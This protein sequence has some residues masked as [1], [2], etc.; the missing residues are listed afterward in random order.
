MVTG[1]GRKQGPTDAQNAWVEKLGALGGTKVEPAKFAGAADETR[2]SL[3]GI[4]PEDIPFTVSCDCTITNDT[5]EILRLDVA[6]IKT[7]SGRLSPA[8]P[9]EIDKR[10]RDVPFRASNNPPFLRGAVG[11]LEYVIDAQGTRWKIGWDNPRFN[12][13]GN[14][15]APTSVEGP[16]K[17]NFIARSVAGP[18]DKAKFS[19]TLKAKGGGGPV[20]PVPPGPTPAEVKSSC[21]VTVTNNTTQ[22]LTLVDQGHARGDFMTFPSS[23]LQPGAA[24]TFASVETPNAKE[25]GCKGFLVWEVGSPAVATWRVGWD[26]PEQAR[27]TT[28]STIDPQTAGFRALDQI[29]QGE[30]NVPVAFTISGGAQGPVPP[31]VPPGPPAP[32][33]PPVPPGPGPEVVEEFDPPVEARQPTLR[34]GDKGKDGWVEYLQQLLNAHLG[35]KLE[36]DGDFGSGTEK[37]VLAFQKKKKLQEDRVVG[38]QTWAALRDGQP[39]KPSTDGRKPHT[40]Q[41]KGAEARWDFER[42]NAIYLSKSDELNMFITSVGDAPI[43]TFKATVRVTPPDTKPKVVRIT[44][45]KPDKVSPTGSGHPHTLR[46]PGFKK[47]FPAKDPN[48]K[49]ETYKL[50]AFLD[51]EL[52]GDLYNGEIIIVDA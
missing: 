7:D 31:P 41:E 46:I 43:D 45:G 18:G 4:G 52:G 28:E 44:I 32:P 19:Y 27:N 40:F 1:E 21:L 23:T 12:P 16:N 11:S 24:T 14:N 50:E 13:F 10:E 9:N 39:E 29:G 25:Q 26:N 20:P 5:D 38:N 22:V 49:V 42:Q 2:S 30:D 15:E 33:G 17:A 8:P 37:A 51:Q 3:L 48:A 36:M 35:I 34:K 47:V 6:S